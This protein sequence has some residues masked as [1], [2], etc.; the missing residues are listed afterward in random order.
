MLKLYHTYKKKVVPFKPI[1][2]GKVGMYN[3]GP[4]VYDSVH[5]GN[6]RAYV[7]ADLL[8][9]G[10]EY[11]GYEV[12]YVMNITD[13]GHLTMTEAQKA[14]RQ[15]QGEK[16][17]ITD[18]D[19]GLD[20]MEKA[21]KREGLT[22]WE[23]A[24]KY[25]VEIFGKD[26]GKSNK[27]G[28]DGDLGKMNILKPHIIC[29]ATDHIQEQIDLIKKLEAK[30]YTYK[31]KKAVYF[32]ITKFSRY[33]GLVGQKFEDMRKGERADTSDPDRNHPA[34]FRLWQL[35]QPDHAMQWDSPWG[36]GF[37]GWHIEC[38]AMSTKY[39]GQPFDIHTGGEDFIKLH[40]A[41]EIAQSECA[42]GKTM[43]NYWLHNAFLTVD[44]RKM[45]KSLGNMY[46]QVDVGK[47][48]FSP[49]DLRYFFLQAHYRT[50]QDFT[51][52]AINA[53]RIALEKLVEKLRFLMGGEAFNHTFKDERKILKKWK[54]RFKKAIEDD[55]NIPKALSIA[56][57]LIKSK[58][59]DKKKVVTILEFD[60][61]FGLE[62]EPWLHIRNPEKLQRIRNLI[63]EREKARQNRNWKKADEIR[64]ELKKRCN[65][66]LKDEKDG[67]SWAIEKKEGGS[68]K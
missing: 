9:R 27:F 11:L 18:T 17:E 52:V 30:G 19:E 55:L 48:G 23:V 3:C 67:P 34:D 36:R 35:D 53:A 59:D 2:E 6:L 37:P 22:V 50:K 8:R 60:K 15:V 5:V 25:I 14:L 65:V 44:G 33:E 40:H 28:Q 29:K 42:Y 24:E 10:L 43:A 56:W 31:T 63:K 58:E 46:T 39:L 68:K 4:T 26:W 64:K 51:W 49:M 1:K 45:G 66:K 20:K 47:K 54:D 62:L 41:N 7:F 57:K 16:L 32:D 38:S 61:V 12:K 13:V 21:A